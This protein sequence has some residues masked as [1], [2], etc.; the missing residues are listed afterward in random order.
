MYGLRERQFKKLFEQ[1][2]EITDIPTGTA[3]LQLLEQRLDNVVYKLGLAKTRPQARQFVTQN[4][5]L[6]DGDTV[7]V[8]SYLIKPGQSVTLRPKEFQSPFIQAILKEAIS[9]PEWLKVEKGQGIVL[10][11][12]LREEIDRDIDENLIISFYTR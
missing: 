7:N 6:V 4:R 2:R 5:V 10:R 9:L 1:A 11:K 8:P 12:P 3:L